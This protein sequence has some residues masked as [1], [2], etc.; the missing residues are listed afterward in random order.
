MSS[1]S[2]SP[3]LRGRNLSNLSNISSVAPFDIPAPVLNLH[4]S[5]TSLSSSGHAHD[6]GDG[7]G[8]DLQPHR[9]PSFLTTTFAS[10]DASGAGVGII[11][12]AMKTKGAT[13]I[14]SGRRRSTKAQI[15]PTSNSSVAMKSPLSP[16]H[17]PPAPKPVVSTATATTTTTVT[18]ASRTNTTL[19]GLLTQA[20]GLNPAL[21]DQ[22]QQEAEQILAEGENSTSN[23][24]HG[25]A[26]GL[27]LLFAHSHD[28]QSTSRAMLFT[29][30]EGRGTSAERSRDMFALIARDLLRM[31]RAFMQRDVG[32][33]VEWGQLFP[34]RTTQLALQ[35]WVTCGIERCRRSALSAARR[36]LLRAQ[37]IDANGMVSMVTLRAFDFSAPR[38]KITHASTAVRS[39]F[40]TRWQD[41]ILDVYYGAVVKVA[42]ER[43]GSPMEVATW[44]EDMVMWALFR[45][46][47]TSVGPVRS[48]SMQVGVPSANSRRAT[49]VFGGTSAANATVMALAAIGVPQSSGMPAP[50][51]P[52]GGRRRSVGKLSFAADIPK[53]EEGLGTFVAEVG[54]DGD[55]AY[56]CMMSLCDFWCESP[57]EEEYIE[58]MATTASLVL[59]RMRIME[60]AAQKINSDRPAPLSIN[61]MAGDGSYRA[62]SPKNAPKRGQSDSPKCA[63]PAVGSPTAAGL[64]ARTF[65]MVKGKQQTANLQRSRIRRQQAKMNRTA[66]KPPHWDREVRFLDSLETPRVLSTWRHYTVSRELPRPHWYE[67]D[68]NEGVDGCI[69]SD[70]T[71]MPGGTAHASDE[72]NDTAVMSLSGTSA[73]VMSPRRMA[74]ALISSPRT[75]TGTGITD[76]AGRL[77]RTATHFRDHPQSTLQPNTTMTNLTLK[78]TSGSEQQ[79]SGGNGS[80]SLSGTQRRLQSMSFSRRSASGRATPGLEPGPRMTKKQR[81]MAEEAAKQR[82]QKL[83]KSAKS[84]FMQPRP[85]PPP[86]AGP[87]DAIPPKKS[88]GCE[89][90]LVVVSPTKALRT[91]NDGNVPK[92]LHPHQT[93]P[94]PA[95]SELFGAFNSKALEYVRTSHGDAFVPSPNVVPTPPPCD[96]SVL[97][98]SLLE[99]SLSV[100]SGRRV[101]KLAAPPHLH[102]TSLSFDPG[103]IQSSAGNS[104]LK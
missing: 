102:L 17:P 58:F 70:P 25:G 35:R 84:R 18:T 10:P 69:T 30:I 82:I 7:D 97:K 12:S 59:T 24:Q 38:R 42:N 88:N 51:S 79:R 44:I 26:Q 68:P 9:M 83:K 27:S 19:W 73:G 55:E 6:D 91:R 37:G 29:G 65:S 32:D 4:M 76:Y 104:P 61:P 1:A 86:A 13:A 63:S 74:T 34:S 22:V 50:S 66:P 28:R 62:G 81:E 46:G 53:L 56:E 40:S 103:A 64:N 100:S 75:K 20:H 80:M 99:A 60:K 15:T 21:L 57:H 98:G 49:S 41:P 54:N 14:F 43:G 89:T 93:P 3:S 48:G 90:I 85:P 5:A 92:V 36:G 52:R 31:R 11:A 39:A 94:P 78:R 71:T 47:G 23:I 95:A 67:V 77:L 101:S 16:V 45:H 33:V 87:E 72:H 96:S 2:P 8:G